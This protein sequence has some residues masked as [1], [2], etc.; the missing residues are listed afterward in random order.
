LGY[1][2]RSPKRQ[3]AADIGAR[4]ADA[5]DAEEFVRGRRVARSAAMILCNGKVPAMDFAMLYGS[6]IHEDFAPEDRRR[7]VSQR[8]GRRLDDSYEN[9]DPEISRRYRAALKSVTV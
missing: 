7:C 1:S 2:T 9:E 8:G 6:R 4:A 5:L 3:R